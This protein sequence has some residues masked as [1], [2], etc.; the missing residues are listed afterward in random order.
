[1]GQRRLLVPSHARPIAAPENLRSGLGWMVRRDS[2]FGL[3]LQPSLV[4]W[5]R[6]T[7]GR[8]P[9]AGGRRG[10]AAAGA[11]HGGLA[12][13]RELSASGIDGGFSEPGCLTVYTELPDQAAGEA[14]SETGRALGAQLLTGPEARELEPALTSAV[15]AGV[16]FPEEASATRSGWSPTSLPLR[17]GRAR[18]SARA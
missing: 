15:Q 5:L 6:A 3:R 13:L 2:P 10:D 12:L 9:R 16:L 17:S 4:P 1:M 7:R 14:A 18:S 11:E 8:R